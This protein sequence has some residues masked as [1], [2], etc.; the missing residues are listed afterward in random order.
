MRV[1]VYGN[2]TVDEINAGGISYRSFG[3]PPVYAGLF[4]V[5]SPIK[6]IV[7]GCAGDEA[8]PASKL[9]KDMGAEVIEP[10]ECRE[11]TM[12]AL[13]KEKRKARVLRVGCEI[14]LRSQISAD[15]HYV[16]PVIGELGAESLE[17]M[18]GGKVYLDPQ[19]FIRRRA[20][21]E[22]EKIKAPSG[23]DLSV[24]FLKAS[25]DEQRYV[26]D[27]RP[28]LATLTFKGG[29]ARLVYKGEEYMLRVKKKPAFDGIGAGDLFGAGFVIG[30]LLDGPRMALAY[31]QAA[32]SLKIGLR[33]LFKIPSFN[34]VKGEA[35][36]LKPRVTDFGF[37]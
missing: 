7:V 22:L 20:V 30:M 5:T 11:T 23:I 28:R 32:A 4:L 37:K 34:E 25:G 6:L 35:E 27:I 10:C 33:G 17:L 26:S 36:R 3:G 19:G 9:L 31:G 12:F 8:S 24:D 13:S 18:T 16:N 15:F 1:A 14:K 21:G 29:L 2:F